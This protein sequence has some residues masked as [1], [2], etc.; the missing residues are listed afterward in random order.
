MKWHI[1]LFCQSRKSTKHSFAAPTFWIPGGDDDRVK[2]SSYEKNGQKSFR[3]YKIRKQIFFDDF[4]NTIR[5]LLESFQRAQKQ[6][7][8][9]NI[10]EMRSIFL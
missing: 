3:L 7:R 4:K 9:I 1:F 6:V 10:R 8:P 2:N 5:L